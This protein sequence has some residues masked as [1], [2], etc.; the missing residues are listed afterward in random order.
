MGHTITEKI[1]AAHAGRRSV[2]AGETVTVRPD[3]IIMSER[4]GFTAVRA[5]EKIGVTRLDEPE[6]VVVVLDHTSQGANTAA[7]V[8]TGNRVLRQWADTQGIK[9]F[10]D[11]GKGG[12]RH[13]VAVEQG[14]ISPGMLCVTDEPNLD[15]MGV[16]GA[17]AYCVGKDVWE[18]MALGEVQMP[19]P[20]S[21]LFRLKG[22]LGPG[23]TTWDLGALIRRDQGGFGDAGRLVEFEV[24]KKIAEFDGPGVASLSI[25]ARMDLL[26]MY[27]LGMGIMNPDEHAVQW[28]VDHGAV[29]GGIVRSDP[30]ATYEATFDYDMTEIV[31][32]VSPP[33]SVRNAVP[34]TDVG[35]IPIHQAV[36]GSCDNGRL[37]DLRMVAE[38]L[39]GKQVHRQ[40]RMIV[41]PI[42]QRVYAQ[43]ARE[44]LLTTM[45]EAGAIVETPGC[46]ACWGY[47]GQLA[48]NE[49]CI[50]TTQHN[51]PGRMGSRQASIFLAN[52]ITVAASAVAG[53]I[54]DPR[55][56]DLE[57]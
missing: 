57:V 30:D 18:P 50:S 5:L 51:Y 12:L 16:L 24:I 35:D 20:Q 23:V 39:R 22:A 56:I 2:S 4:T 8:V 19:V 15:N 29:A 31:P 3:I 1:I 49:V 41:A 32:H 17:L 7:P 37:E 25:D 43:A 34:V 40:V 46:G 9:A 26:A 21:V 10:H 28:T 48:D 13:Q 6:K 27:P 54:V 36:V 11:A 38:V 42:T 45:A 44:G 52:P 14:Y 55:S 53:R 33:P 47:V